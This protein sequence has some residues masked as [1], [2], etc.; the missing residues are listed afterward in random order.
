MR[1][2]EVCESCLADVETEPTRSDGNEAHRNVANHSNMTWLSNGKSKNPG[3]CM[4]VHVILATYMH[5]HT[6]SYMPRSTRH[7]GLIGGIPQRT[8]DD[9]HRKDIPRTDCRH[10]W[11]L[12]SHSL[13]PPATGRRAPGCCKLVQRHWASS[14]VSAYG[15]GW[16]SVPIIGCCSI[17]P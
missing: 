4:Y 13:S 11:L 8:D 16:S 9:S 2:R 12:Q 3:I 15:A 14:Q 17:D 10:W 6:W 1:S 5:I 7:A